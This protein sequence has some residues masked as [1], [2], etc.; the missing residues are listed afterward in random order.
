MVFVIFYLIIYKLN[1]YCN[2]LLFNFHRITI[3]ISPN[4]IEESKLV[5]PTKIPPIFLFIFL[6][7]KKY[8]RIRIYLKLIIFWTFLIEV[9]TQPTR[10]IHINM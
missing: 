5:R 7:D 9:I 10:G 1:N 2:S 4:K 6:L 3:I 8:Y